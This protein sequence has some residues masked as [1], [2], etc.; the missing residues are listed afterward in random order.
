LLHFFHFNDSDIL[1]HYLCL[2]IKNCIFYSYLALLTLCMSII[3]LPYLLF[4]KDYLRHGPVRFWAGS[5]LYLIRIIYKID[6][7]LHQS[8]LSNDDISTLSGHIIAIAHQSF[9]DILIALYL[10]PRGVFVLKSSIRYIFPLHLYIQKLGYIYV[11]R[12]KNGQSIPNLV[13]GAKKALSD[14]DNLFIYPHGSRI[15]PEKAA[16]FKKGIF[17]LAETLPDAPILPVIHQAGLFWG[18]RSFLKKPGMILWQC[19]PIIPAEKD[20][21]NDQSAPSPQSHRHQQLKQFEQQCNKYSK[22]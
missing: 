6:W 22:I 8:H 13:A 11:N 14:G 19:L 9:L 20:S 7:T 5:L 18:R 16:T 17:I 15:D 1:M 21:Q 4:P 2:L 3:C 12:G 10:F